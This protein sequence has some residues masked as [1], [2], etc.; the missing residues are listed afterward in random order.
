MV[1]AYSILN[2]NQELLK[3]F[4]L[5]GNRIGDHQIERV[6]NQN[7]R[8]LEAIEKRMLTNEEIKVSKQ[9]ID[10]V[11]YK[12]QEAAL[13]GNKDTKIWTIRELRIVSYYIMKLQ[14]DS[15]VYHYALNLLDKNW[16]NLFFNGLVF[17]VMNSW[18]MIR[19][20]LRIDTCRL[21][22]KKLQNYSDNNRK[23]KLY[24]N[25]ANLFEE[26]GPVRMAAI[27]LGKEQNISDAPQLLGNRFSSIAQS[28]YSD[29]IVKYYEKNNIDLEEI[30]ELFETHD[31]TR[32]KKLLF[33]NL[34]E[35]ADRSG[36]VILQIQLSKLINRLLGDVTL[37][38][39]WAP[40][41]GASEEDAQKLK[42]AMQLVNLWFTRRVI[43]TFFEIC[44]QDRDRK[45]FWL[46]YV[47]YV[48]GFKIVG[49][50]L[51]KQALQNDTR[52]SSLFSSHFIETNSRYSQTS[53]L[54]LS[55]KD[56]VVIEFSDTGAL[57]VYN[58][59]DNRVS[60]LRKGTKY[61]NSTSELKTPSMRMLVDMDYWYNYF[62]DD[63][64]MTHQGKWKDRLEGWLYAKVLSD[65]NTTKSFF[66]TNYDDTFVAQD[67][68]KETPIVK[69][70][71]EKKVKVEKIKVVD[72]REHNIETQSSQGQLSN[73][74]VSVK[75][76]SKLIFGASCRVI[77]N[78]DGYYLNYL[79][80]M[81]F[82]FLRA[83]SNGTSPIGNIWIKN[84][85]ENGW[86]PI[87]HYLSGREILVGYIKQGANNY[88]FKCSLNQSDYLII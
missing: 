51:T 42:R 52:T 37:V 45:M 6:F 32:T 73:N 40:F 46:N 23:Y 67:L 35:R 48:S 59:N 21:V 41:P 47:Q 16:K 58:Q 25:H 3:D 75:I 9:S 63:G 62:N 15:K 36:D 5:L 56:K 50:A 30:E 78:P 79:K 57:Y 8:K 38:S 18:N 19:K 81:K 14:N 68:P 10:E 53:A 80:G 28:Y 74:R 44:V 66:D 72:K 24:K 20:E 11:L 84:P 61:M 69:P 33:A 64:R 71:T 34:V 17:Y 31:V 4:H 83:L 54:V 82:Y 12:V 1:D 85:E 86:H 27:L 65:N 22:V 60:F 2:I 87:I 49:S 39:T 7:L 76:A 70:N 43:E 77:C 13:A 26:A 88:L 55:M 29:V